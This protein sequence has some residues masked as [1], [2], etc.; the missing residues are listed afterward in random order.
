M[1]LISASLNEEGEV[2]K[3]QGIHSKLL[4]N[5]RLGAPGFIT[6]T[7]FDQTNQTSQSKETFL[8][9]NLAC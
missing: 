1:G 3:K 4:C 7:S 2:Q 9:Q 5:M 8:D 6:I